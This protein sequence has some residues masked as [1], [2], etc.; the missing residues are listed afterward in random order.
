VQKEK[1]LFFSLP[2]LTGSRVSSGLPLRVSRLSGVEFDGHRPVIGDADVHVGPEDTV[3]HLVILVVSFERFQEGVVELLGL[4]TLHGL[5]EI[6]LV[7]LQ[8]CVQRELAY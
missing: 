4:V 1:N 2:F 7:L 3:L 6:K 5:V 8:Q